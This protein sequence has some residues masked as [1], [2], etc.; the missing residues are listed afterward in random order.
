[1]ISSLVAVIIATFTYGVSSVLQSVGARRAASG[2]GGL[3]SITG[4]VRQL[5]YVGGLACDLV[6]WILSLYALR[7]LP[8]FAVQT[9][10]AGSLAVTAV[11]SH[12]VLSVAL[13]RRVV[14]AIGLCIVG[15]VLVGASAGIERP[16]RIERYLTI[17][18]V[19][20]VVVVAAA[21]LAAHRWS[22]AVVLAAVS[23]V[24][25]AGTALS[26][27]ALLSSRH[28]F[29]H[30]FGLRTVGIIG[31]AIVGLIAHARALQRGR[32]GPVTAAM[33]ASQIVVATIV[34][35]ALLG[36]QVRHGWGVVAIVGLLI[37][38]VATVLLSRSRELSH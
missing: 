29:H 24:A 31:Y 20:G 32:V 8:V 23:G 26:A 11:V 17:S 14:R 38:T 22:S 33:W 13:D 10:L 19:V 37:A 27:R 5:P 7:S 6:A 18:L 9:I 34:G 35:L 2:Q 15:L 36:D 28:P 21:A 4:L 1:M 25:F 30:L 3:A 16:H 12:F